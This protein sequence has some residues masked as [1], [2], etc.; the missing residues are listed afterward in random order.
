MP[1]AQPTPFR[2]MLDILP[3]PA[4]FLDPAVKRV[5]G[6]N[7]DFCRLVGYMEQE[8]LELPCQEIFPPEQSSASAKETCIC[9][10]CEHKSLQKWRL[11]RHDGSTLDFHIRYTF[12]RLMGPDGAIHSLCLTTIL[13]AVA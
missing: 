12:T 2:H 7:R 10:D 13:G 1:Q 6:A 9:D 5:V 3:V 4:C 11:R 8:I